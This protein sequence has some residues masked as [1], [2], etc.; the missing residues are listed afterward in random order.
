[1]NSS[2]IALTDF[3]TNRGET[4]PLK[5][6]GKIMPINE[7]DKK[8]VPKKPLLRGDRGKFAK[9]PISGP[10]TAIE[11]AIAI[12]SKEVDK[13]S[14]TKPLIESN[15]KEKTLP[16]EVPFDFKKSEEITDPAPQ[17]IES[18]EFKKGINTLKICLLKLPN[19]TYRIKVFLNDT[20]EVR[21][22][23]CVGFLQ[24]DT[25]WKLIKGLVQ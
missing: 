19:R 6:T 8:E 17:L 20:H 4:S 14:L 15:N 16:E 23:S 13:Y 9:K 5:L 7:A 25:F 22:I 3:N 24:A 21:P 18:I 11:N 12:V 10:A 2:Y 1:M